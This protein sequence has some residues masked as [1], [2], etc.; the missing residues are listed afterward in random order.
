MPY[1]PAGVARHSPLA[2]GGID[3]MVAGFS[4]HR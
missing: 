3:A 4:G 1:R 2:A